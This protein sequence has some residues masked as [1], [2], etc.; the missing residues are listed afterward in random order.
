MTGCEI[1]CKENLMCDTVSDCC[2]VLPISEA[3]PVCT[4]RISSLREKTDSAK[5]KWCHVSPFPLVNCTLFPV[6]YLRIV[7][8]AKGRTNSCLW[9]SLS[10]KEHKMTAFIYLS[11]H[12]HSFFLIWTS[13]SAF[14]I[15]NHRISYRLA[16][17]VCYVACVFARCDDSFFVSNDVMY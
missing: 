12:V 15:M 10:D 3:R 16:L 14:W 8:V 13:T 1:L 6:I 11:Y 17:C 7:C 2:T 9:D 4:L 5:E